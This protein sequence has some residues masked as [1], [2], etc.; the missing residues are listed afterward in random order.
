VS[1]DLTYRRAGV[2]VEAADRLVARIAGLAA[3]T[4]GPEVEPGP[5]AFA[6]LYR[7]PG[8]DLLAATCDG[9]GTKVLIAREAGRFEGIG[10]DLVAMN[11]ND[12]L[13]V[14]ARPL[15]FLDYLAAGALDPGPVAAVVAG[16]AAACREVGCALLGGETAEMPGLYRPGDLDVAGFAVGLVDPRRRPD[17]AGPRPGDRVLALPSSGIHANGL[18]LAR[19]ALLDRGGLRLDGHV[20]E[21]GRTLAEELLEPTALYAGPVLGAPPGRVG[22]LAHV[23][24]GGLA[25]RGRAMLPEGLHMHLDP[26]R[27]RRPPVFDL[28]ERAGPVSGTEMAAT[29]NLG[30]GFLAIVDPEAAPA[31]EEDGWLPVGDV[32][33]GERGVSLDG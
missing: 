28:I 29:F 11:V 17:P 10:Q 21:L 19:A 31:W 26:A 30:L 12:L 4:H 3:A 33:P 22:A 9:V 20:P 25:R 5:A 18:S 6:G 16:A 23:T 14:G 7:L 15:F 2:D 24:G 32:R 1:G 13:P 8:G 27:W